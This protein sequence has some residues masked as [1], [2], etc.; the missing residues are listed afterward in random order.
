MFKNFLYVILSFFKD[1]WNPPPIGSKAR[2][3]MPQSYFLLPSEKKFPYKDPKTGKIS[4]EGLMSQM[5]RAQ[6]HGYK[7]V[8]QKAQKLYNQHCKSK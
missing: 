5:R 6:Q 4:C 7:S 3:Q 2:S 1:K 8:F